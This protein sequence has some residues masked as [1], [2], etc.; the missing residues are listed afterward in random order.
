MQLEDVVSSLYHCHCIMLYMYYAMY[1]IQAALNT[2]I[3]TSELKSN[4]FGL[5]V[6]IPFLVIRKSF[7]DLYQIKSVSYDSFPFCSSPQFSFVLLV[8]LVVYFV[9]FLLSIL[10]SF[11][12]DFLC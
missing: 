10:C 4:L 12:I 3:D 9:V 1:R 11:S 2:Q 6:F 5:P 8:F 7:K